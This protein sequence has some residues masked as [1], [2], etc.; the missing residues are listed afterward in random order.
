M[1][2]TNEECRTIWKDAKMY[3]DEGMVD[4]FLSELTIC[5]A[6]ILGK[7]RNTLLKIILYLGKSTCSG[8]S[9]GSMAFSTKE[10]GISTSYIIGVMSFAPRLLNACGSKEPHVLTRV[11]PYVD[12]I[13]A[14]IE[15][16]QPPR[17]RKYW[18]SNSCACC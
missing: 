14:K 13:R 12:W 3:P 6:G 17:C 15:G 11:A 7:Y 4:L 9:G 2:I 8:D 18:S 5:P 10:N 1:T 16:E